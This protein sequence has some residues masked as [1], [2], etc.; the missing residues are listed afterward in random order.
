M[1]LT[2]AQK[3]RLLN[4]KNQLF[5]RVDPRLEQVDNI[6]E[7]V[8]MTGITSDDLKALSNPLFV[9]GLDFSTIDTS[10]SFTTRDMNTIAPGAIDV[11][12]LKTKIMNQSIVK[13]RVT[14]II[15]TQSGTMAVTQEFRDNMDVEDIMEFKV[16]SQGTNLQNEI[17]AA[18]V[19]K[20]LVKD[21]PI[22]SRFLEA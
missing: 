11:Q 18:E 8:D 21:K 13:A 20:E 4:L 14:D 6:I 10:G 16:K 12:E 3:E 2:D 5:N 17:K 7:V 1:A 9:I 22:K 19:D 15:D